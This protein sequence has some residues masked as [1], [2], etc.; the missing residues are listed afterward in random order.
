M[1]DAKLFLITGKGGAGKTTV[2]AAL[3]SI[4]ARYKERTLLVESVADGSLARLFGQERFAS[5]PHMVRDHLFGVR[6]DPSLLLEGYVSRILPLPWL[7]QRLLASSAF[8]ALG[9]AAPGVSEFLLLERIAMWVD[10]GFWRRRERYHRVIVDGPA[11]GHMLHL[12]RA[13]RQLLNLVPGGPLHRSLLGIQTLLSDP[14]RTRIVVVTLPEELG[15]EETAEAYRVLEG[16]L[17]LPVAPPVVNRTPSCPFQAEERERIL[18]RGD[19]G[20]VYAAARYVIERRGL[21]EVLIRRLRR[22]IGRKPVLLPELERPPTKETALRPL[23]LA[24][25]PLL[26][27][28]TPATIESGSHAIPR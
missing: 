16:E 20:P 7:A 28:G 17:F 18:R 6:V 5:Q 1:R 3:A 21:A 13:P 10:P 4:F 26:D 23:A 11:T 9:A 22:Q 14:Q 24:L 19:G 8:R 27:L 15:I 25:E 12:L 2:A